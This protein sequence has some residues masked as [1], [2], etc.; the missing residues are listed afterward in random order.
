[1]ARYHYDI[2]GD[3]PFLDEEGAEHLDDKAAWRDAVRLVRDVEEHLAPDGE[4]FLTVREGGRT[5]Y[6][7][8]VTSR[9][10]S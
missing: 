8:G 1:M 6:S 3:Y 2:S 10:H 9:T 7:I 5:V 4:W